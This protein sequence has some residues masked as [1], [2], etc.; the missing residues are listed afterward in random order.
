MTE[1]FVHVVDPGSLLGAP[2]RFEVRESAAYEVTIEVFA[3]R[4]AADIRCKTLNNVSTAEQEPNDA[5]RRI[6]QVSGEDRLFLRPNMIQG[7]HV[8]RWPSGK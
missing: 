7:A 1:Y 4:E 2:A 8:R 5:S 6:A 3:T